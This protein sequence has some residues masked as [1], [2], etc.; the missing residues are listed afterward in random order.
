[1]C[2]YVYFQ[3]I[4]NSSKYTYIQYIDNVFYTYVLKILPINIR[5]VFEM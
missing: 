5:P 4:K 2:A 3:D 1:M